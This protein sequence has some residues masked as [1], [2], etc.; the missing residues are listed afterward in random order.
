MEVGGDLFR[1][2]S[3]IY[4]VVSREQFPQKGPIIDVSLGSSVHLW[5]EGRPK[6]VRQSLL[7]GEPYISIGEPYRGAFGKFLTVF[8]VAT[9]S[10]SKKL[11][12]SQ[13][14]PRKNSVFLV[15]ISLIS[16]SHLLFSLC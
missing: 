16:Y 11:Y 9:D 2:L 7:Q 13:D 4:D 10:N 6:F 8:M 3:S 14:Q 15:K 12:L 5:L 1:A